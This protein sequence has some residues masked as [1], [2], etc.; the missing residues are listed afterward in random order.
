MEDKI[1]Y[2]N[3]SCKVCGL[4]KHV[5]AWM[6]SQL[7]LVA[8]NQ[9]ETKDLNSL[10][11]Y[12][13]KEAERQL[14]EA[15]LTMLPNSKTL[16]E[17]SSPLAQLNNEDYFWIVDP[18]DGTTNFLH[19]LPFF[20]I[21]VALYKGGEIVLG[22]VYEVNREEL[23]YSWKGAKAAYLN[24]K[25][26]SVSQKERFPDTLLA[27]GFPYYD[28]AYQTHYMKLFAS[29]MTQV[30]GLRRFGSAA[31]D[32]AY[33]ACGRFDG[34]FEYSLSPWD[35]A[36]GAFLV[37]QAGGTVTDFVGGRNYLLGKTIVAASLYTHP[38]L[39]AEI[40]LYF[41]MEDSLS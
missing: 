27:T 20:S 21:S 35:V 2:E 8:D 16:A 40:A 26:I 23:F 15:L 14:L 9:V 4:V 28:F 22:V 32:L 10:V 30:R 36:A 6:K 38:K 17:E 5:G 39:Q 11:S 1:L 19:Q 3:L 34:F 29:L 13:D 25:E 12:V 41:Q 24:G 7:G 31:L 37:Q 18:L 33:T